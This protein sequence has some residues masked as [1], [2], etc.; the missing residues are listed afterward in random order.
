[1]YMQHSTVRQVV[2][3]WMYLLFRNYT[4][5]E[6]TYCSAIWLLAVDSLE[7]LKPERGSSALCSVLPAG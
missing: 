5:T 6:K 4:S 7:D 3:K 1:M 2:S